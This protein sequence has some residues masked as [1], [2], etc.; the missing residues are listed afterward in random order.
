ML[1]N[2]EKKILESEKKPV[3]KM[4]KSIV[5]KKYHKGEKVSLESVT[6]KSPGGGLPP[7]K[8]YELENKTFQVSL[9]EDEIIKL[10]H[11]E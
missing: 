4:A 10:E 5:A 3:F 11:I 7:Y 2:N 6:F 1:G 8:F 9:K